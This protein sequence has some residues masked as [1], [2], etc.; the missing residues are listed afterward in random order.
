MHRESFL[1]VVMGE[2]IFY[3]TFYAYLIGKKAT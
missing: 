2:D 3:F 1:A